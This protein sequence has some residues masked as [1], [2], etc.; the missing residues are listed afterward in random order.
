MRNLK[1]FEIDAIVNTVV[2]QLEKNVKSKFIWLNEFEEINKII[3]EKDEEIDKLRDDLEKLK[4]K[5]RNEYKTYK[6][7]NFYY[8][9]EFIQE[10]KLTLVDYKIKQKIENEIIISNLKD[11]NVDNLIEKLIEKFS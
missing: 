1:K 4:T 3:K 10:T 9:D 5:Y 7:I 2:E 6:G 11:E 8:N